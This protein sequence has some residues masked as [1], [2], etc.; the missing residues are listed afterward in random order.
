MPALPGLPFL[1]AA[2]AA[3]SDLDEWPWDPPPPVAEA[4]ARLAAVRAAHRAAEARFNVA[5]RAA[6]AAWH[7][8]CAALLAVQDADQ[9]LAEARRAAAGGTAP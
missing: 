5:N 3:P 1:A 9:V 7:G 4:E 8:M 2:P 6:Q